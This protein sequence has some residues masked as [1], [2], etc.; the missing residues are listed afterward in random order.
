MKVGPAGEILFKLDPVQLPNGFVLVGL[1][2]AMQF[3][4]GDVVQNE[5]ISSDVVS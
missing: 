4:V 1:D 3:A 5:S 2:E